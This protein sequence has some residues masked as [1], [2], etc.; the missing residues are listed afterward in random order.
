MHHHEEGNEIEALGVL[1]RLE[2]SSHRVGS[3][4]AC[5][6]VSGEA[7]R[8][9][10][11]GVLGIPEHEQVSDQ[12]WKPEI[13]DQYRAGENDEDDVAGGYWKSHSEYETRQKQKYQGKKEIPLGK[14]KHER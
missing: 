7:H 6:G 2:P 4:H 13:I 1:P 9:G 10:D 3:C 5:G 8:R 12:D 11:V 14:G